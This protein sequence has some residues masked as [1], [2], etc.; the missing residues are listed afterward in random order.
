VLGCHL[1]LHCAHFL[2]EE[3]S[4]KGRMKGNYAR[5][6]DWVPYRTLY[7]ATPLLVATCTSC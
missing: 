4:D 6:A 1:S 5:D 3:R 7:A 2:R